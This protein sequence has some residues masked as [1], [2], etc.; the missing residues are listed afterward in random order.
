MFPVGVL[1]NNTCL[2]AYLLKYAQWLICDFY[3]RKRE[4]CFITRSVFVSKVHCWMY[5]LWSF[6][7]LVEN[8]LSSLDWVLSCL[9]G[10]EYWRCAINAWRFSV[11][12]IS[13]KRVLLFSSLGAETRSD[14]QM[15]EQTL[16]ILLFKLSHLHYW[17][18][19]ATYDYLDF[20]LR[21]PIGLLILLSVLWFEDNSHL[22]WKCGIQQGMLNCGT[23]RKCSWVTWN[24]LLEISVNI[25]WFQIHLD[26]LK[27]C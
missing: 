9:D 15:Q 25:S 8:T 12:V 19:A 4:R 22:S 18:D 14:W 10:T 16:K 1:L 5:Y 20:V 7:A 17:K 2:C 27:I 13:I 23:I 3:K 11:C 24:I 21:T 26:L 6:M